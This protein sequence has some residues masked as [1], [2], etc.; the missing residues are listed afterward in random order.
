MCACACGS[1]HFVKYNRCQRFIQK[2]M[3]LITSHF[4]RSFFCSLFFSSELF[5]YPFWFCIVA[6]MSHYSIRLYVQML[7]TWNG[8]MFNRTALFTFMCWQQ[9]FMATFPV[10]SDSHRSVRG[11]FIH[12]IFVQPI[13]WTDRCI[14]FSILSYI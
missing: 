2:N 8:V 3:D 1:V 5:F 14:D 9:W 7:Y 4:F 12:K 10:L 11:E 6:N 13:H